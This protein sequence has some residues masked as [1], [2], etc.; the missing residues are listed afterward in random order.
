MA[1]SAGIHHIKRK[2]EACQ[3]LSAP[4]WRLRNYSSII[5]NNEKLMLVL[6]VSIHF[7]WSISAVFTTARTKEHVEV[8]CGQN[9]FLLLYNIFLLL[10]GT[11]H[12]PCWRRCCYRLSTIIRQGPGHNVQEL[13]GR[14]YRN[15]TINAVALYIQEV[16]PKDHTITL[17]SLKPCWSKQ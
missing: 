10:H 14:R 13:A 12:P 5:H 6:S 7:Q 11:P 16:A 3:N 17:N 4:F 9:Y 8:T 2:K 1:F 15:N